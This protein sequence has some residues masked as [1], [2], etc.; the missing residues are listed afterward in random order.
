[1]YRKT[2]LPASLRY[3]F[4]IPP[5]LWPFVWAD[6]HPP[7]SMASILKDSAQA[8]NKTRQSAIVLTASLPEGSAAEHFYPQAHVI[9]TFAD[10]FQ[11]IA[12]KITASL[13]LSGLVNAQSL[14]YVNQ[15]F[16]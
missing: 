2:V 10:S 5:F 16:L 12:G 8:Q 15:I 6:R 11:Q 9:G 4:S 13:G 3:I 14:D 1:M 7:F